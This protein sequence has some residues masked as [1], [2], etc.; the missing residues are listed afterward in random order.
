[1]YTKNNLLLSVPSSGGFKEKSLVEILAFEAHLCN[2]RFEEKNYSL[3]S[4]STSHA[5]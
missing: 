1:M 2:I 3:N 4:K 5:K